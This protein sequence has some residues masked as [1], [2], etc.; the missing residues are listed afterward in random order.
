MMCGCSG[1]G[2]GDGTRKEPAMTK[3]GCDGARNKDTPQ[4]PCC[5]AESTVVGP[6]HGLKRRTLEVEF[7]YLDLNTCDRCKGADEMLEEAL[8]E[9]R[10]ILGPTGVDVTLKKIHVRTEAQALRVGLVSSPTVRVMGRDA[11]I[12]VKESPCAGCSDLSATET[13]CRVWTW[14]GKE[15]SV[16]PKAMI[17]DAILREAYLHP[18][19]EAKP[20]PPLTELPENMKRFFKGIRKD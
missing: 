10:K 19:G 15:Y 16:P 14:R 9:A 6:G 11:A 7:L 13:T 12:D 1:S 4:G 5:A 8:E 20:V 2:Q 17:L 18:A 3:C